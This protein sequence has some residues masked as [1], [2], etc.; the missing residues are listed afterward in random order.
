MSRSQFHSIKL[1]ILRHAWLNLWDKHMTTGRINQVTFLSE[2]SLEVKTLNTNGARGHRACIL[3]TFWKSKKRRSGS[4]TWCVPHTFIFGSLVTF[5][6]TI[7]QNKATVEDQSISNL[8]R[9]SEVRCLMQTIADTQAQQKGAYAYHGFANGLN[10]Y[11][12]PSGNV[13]RLFT[14]HTEVQKL[15]CEWFHDYPLNM[16]VGSNGCVKQAS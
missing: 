13:Y 1:F 10:L 15:L 14:S 3:L 2:S 8:E 6:Y 4:D 7:H 11:A 5:H 9:P 12:Y 16:T